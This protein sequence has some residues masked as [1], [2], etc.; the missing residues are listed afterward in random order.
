LRFQTANRN[1]LVGD[2]APL[3]RAALRLTGP[4]ESL[5]GHAARPAFARSMDKTVPP[6]RGRSK[7][8]SATSIIMARILTR[9]PA[10]ST[11]FFGDPGALRSPI[12]TEHCA[13]AD[14][15]TRAACNAAISAVV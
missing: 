11:L 15:I 8:A 13:A 2:A 9:S 7:V 6:F 14:Q 1:H 12:I 10:L 4:A 5:F 3:Y